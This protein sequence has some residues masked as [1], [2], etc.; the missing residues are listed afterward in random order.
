MGYTDRFRKQLL[1]SRNSDWV[2]EIFKMQSLTKS[3]SL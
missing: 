2:K 3:V 1:S